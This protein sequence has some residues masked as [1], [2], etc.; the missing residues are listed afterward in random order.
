MGFRFRR[1]IKI[2][3]G[4]RL[5]VGKRGISTTLGGRG[6]SI[7]VGSKGVY[8]NTGIP[9]TGLSYRSKIAG[10]SG[11]TASSSA[12]N[13]GGAQVS[14]GC[15]GCGCFGFLGLGFLLVIG[16][17]SSGAP[18]SSTS[19]YDS[20]PLALTSPPATTQETFYL[21]GAMNVRSGPG[22]ANPVTRTLEKG[23]RVVLGPKD[24]SGWAEV[25]V[26]GAAAGYLYRGSDLVQRTPP[27]VQTYT[28]APS[29]SRTNGYYRGPRGG[30]YTYTSGGN[31]RY[32]DRSLC[33]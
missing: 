19:S 28:S 32:V 3:P 15:A 30:C 20:E 23:T 29:R 21:H 13:T 24:A 17:C 31:K 5:N 8:A 11:R 26:A 14:S 7:N 18:T 27:P 16:M 25:F 2:A 4:I 22:T 33:N 10:G 12:G 9:G 6:A 1:S